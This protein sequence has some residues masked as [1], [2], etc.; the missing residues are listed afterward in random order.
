[1]KKDLLSPK[2]IIDYEREAY[3]LPFEDIRITFDKNV[4][5][6][7]QIEAFWNKDLWMKQV[8][9]K[10]I[11]VLEI[12]YNTMLPKWLR[13]ALTLVS[14]TRQSVSKYCLSRLSIG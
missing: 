14:S 3:R 7:N 9:E 8:F 10:N 2:V 12:K 6:S 5:A 11:I 4:R 13:D 1:M